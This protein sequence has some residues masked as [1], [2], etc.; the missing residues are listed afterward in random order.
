MSRIQIPL[1]LKNHQHLRIEFSEGGGD[2]GRTSESG[3]IRPI[4]PIKQVLESKTMFLNA[5]QADAA[6]PR[7]NQVAV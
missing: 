6:L 3:A 4:Q 7:N 1:F 2:D 5:L